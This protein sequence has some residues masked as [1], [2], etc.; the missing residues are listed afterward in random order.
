MKSEFDVLAKKYVSDVKKLQKTCP[1]KRNSGWTEQWWAFGPW[2]GYAV[3]ACLN[4]NKILER[5]K[6]FDKGT[7]WN[8]KQAAR[9]MNRILKR[10]RAALL[11]AKRKIRK[12][13]MPVLG[14]E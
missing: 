10:E 6:G 3:K 9:E 8:K 1:H 2:T 11:E 5:K 14:M 12:G 7:R 13:R 4:C